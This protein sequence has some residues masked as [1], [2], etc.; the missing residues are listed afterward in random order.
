L[1]LLGG[2]SSEYYQTWS[3]LKALLIVDVMPL[4]LLVPL[5]YYIL[6]YVV[7]HHFVLSGVVA[8][9]YGS[10]PLVIYDY[11]FIG[12]YLNKGM[13][14]LTDYWYLTVFYFVPWAVIPLVGYAI[15]RKRSRTTPR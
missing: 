14:F 12:K 13:A 11:I 7:G 2:L 1:F 3:F 15:E 4:I 6:K 8:A 10:V 9:F 5:S